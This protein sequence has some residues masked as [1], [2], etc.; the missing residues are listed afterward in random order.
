M[1]DKEKVVIGVAGAVC[2]GKTVVSRI[3]QQLGAYYIS[4]DMIG[5]QVLP[6]IADELKE[7]FGEDIMNGGTIDRRKL[8]DIV[9]AD[10]D[11]VA[12]LNQLS[13]PRLVSKLIEAIA[14]ATARIVVV[15]AALLFEWPRVLDVVDVP[16]LIVAHEQLQKERA[17]TEGMDEMTFKRILHAQMDQMLTQKKAAYVIENNGTLDELRERCE[18]IY[19]EIQRDC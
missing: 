18:E 5:W 2:S 14:D 19:Q 11:N 4:A 1:H 15:D 10:D 7:R 9:F 13:H 8:R 6:D 12:F 3:F 17:V 16:I